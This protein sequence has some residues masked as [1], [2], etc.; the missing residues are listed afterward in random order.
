MQPEVKQAREGA[1]QEEAKESIMDK[2]A[3]GKAKR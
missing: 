2:L 3:K 1:G